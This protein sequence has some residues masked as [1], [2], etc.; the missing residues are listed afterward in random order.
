MQL[1]SNDTFEDNSKL[2]NPQA[3]LNAFLS[4]DRYIQNLLNMLTLDSKE[5]TS[6]SNNCSGHGECLNNSCFCEV[7]FT[8]SSCDNP[9]ISY[10]V[11]FS[12]I[13]FI[14]CVISFIQLILCINS[15]FKREKPRSLVKALRIT[16]QKA[17]YFFIFIAT[18]IRGFYFQSS[19]NES[20]RWASDLKS[21]Y[22]PLL[23]S[24]SSL[25]V[26]LW[27]EVFHLNDLSTERPGFL[28][29]SFCGFILFNVITYSLFIAELILI[30]YLDANSLEKTLFS[31]I[32][33]SIYAAFMLIVV[34]FFLI[35]GIEVYVKV[36]G[37]FIKDESLVSDKSQLHQSRLGF[38]SQA[39][40]LTFTV[41]FILSDVLGSF[42]K[43]KVPVVS[44][45]TYQIM[46]QIVE[47]AVALWFPCCL[48][49]C[50]AGE[51]LWLLNPRRILKKVKNNKTNQQSE[52][53]D[54]L[55]LKNRLNDKLECWICYDN[56]KSDILI[57]PCQ[58]K[59]DVSIVHHDC[60]KNWLRESNL[61]TKNIRCKVCNEYYQLS[62]GE[63]WLPDGLEL[64]HYLKSFAVMFVMGST[65]FSAYF[66][67]RIYDYGYV[68]TI[69][70][71][72]ATLIE[73][74][75]LK[76]L[77][78]N[79]LSAYH[80]AKFA[81]LIIK[82][83]ILDDSQH[84]ILQRDSSASNDR[85]ST[86]CE[87]STESHDDYSNES[88][89]LTILNDVETRTE[90]V[91][92]FSMSADQQSFNHYDN[93]SSLANHAHQLNSVNSHSSEQYSFLNQQ[94]SSYQL[95]P[96]MMNHSTVC[97]SK[98]D[99]HTKDGENIENI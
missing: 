74:I 25:I 53:F 96:S 24:G 79:L 38:I 77:G 87:S 99:D 47:L 11:A 91:Q 98:Y 65:V 40:L 36:R 51:T 84:N 82:G 21:A 2:T 89:S 72:V 45:N 32:F 26:C 92:P 7:E 67:V 68:R 52:S 23:L 12:T 83:K 71:G 70:V 16:T 22:Y 50:I 42:W 78:V 80:K 69:S 34:V 76:I 75:C 73:Y 20:L 55:M 63:I 14:L 35:Y 44:R 86:A 95:Q 13:F 62:K 97:F 94:Q 27:A 6:C 29:K 1:L 41:F 37:A 56:D 81:A 54:N 49:N 39:I 61:S 58:C 3:K 59:G 90:I 9:N 19:F 93:R 30:K 17:L 57:Q 15:E 88:D 31:N 85:L 66:L 4:S 60:L 43:A 28:S 18:A 8:G 10:Y 48:W 33:N 64:N 46:F 5:S